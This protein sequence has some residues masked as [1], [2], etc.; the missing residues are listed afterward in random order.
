MPEIPP[1]PKVESGRITV[2]GHPGKK[3]ARSHVS[4]QLDVVMHAFD[5]SS[6]GG[7]RIAV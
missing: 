4:N 2:E 6:V 1:T 5:P 7:Q 3:L